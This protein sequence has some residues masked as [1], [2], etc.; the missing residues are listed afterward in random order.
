M[1]EQVAIGITKL[2]GENWTIWKF[3][4]QVTLKSK[5]YFAVVEGIT[6]RPVPPAETKDWDSKDARAQE[7]IVSRVDDKIV[8]HLLTCQTSADMWKKLKNI[9]EHQSQ[10]SVHLLTQKF[11]SLQYQEGHTAE[12]MSQLEEIKGNLKALGEEISDKM[13]VTKVLMSLPENMKHFVT[14]WESTPEANR[15]LTDLMS[16]LMLEEERNKCSETSAAL[17]VQKLAIR[18]EYNKIGHKTQIKCFEC[19]GPHLRRNC[20]NLVKINC[21]FCKKPGHKEQFCWFKKQKDKKEGQRSSN[22]ALISESVILNCCDVIN[23]VDKE[24]LNIENWWMDSGSTEHMCSDRKQFRA[25]ENVREKKQV[26]V[27]NGTMVDVKG[28][29]TV[30]VMAWNGKEWV[31]TDLNNALYIPELAVNLFSLSTALDKNLEMHS[32]K[33]RCQL[34]DKEGK[35]KAIAKRQGNLYKMHFKT[36]NFV[37]EVTSEC[38][39]ASLAE[40]HCRLAHINFEQ[41][42]K[43]LKRNAIEYTEK[44]KPFCTSCLS[45]KQHRLPFPRSQTITEKIGDLV[46]GD[47]EGPIE[48]SSVGGARYFLLMKDDYSRYRYVYF[49]KQKSEAFENIKKFINMV[50][51]QTE[52][53]VKKLRTD[54]GL[55]FINFDLKRLADTKGFIHETTCSDTPQQNGRAEREMRTIME[56][57]RTQLHAKSIDKK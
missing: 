49:M 53:K 50:E 37:Q 14:A 23:I 44:E 10:V 11:F 32:D 47:L 15:T 6:Q 55:E 46:H 29:G 38:N 18:R 26:R 8:T 5:G 57:C 19:E 24:N 36:Q 54:N 48:V 56:A 4:V 27:G 30:Q 17:A 7:I 40:W 25:M 12:F 42:R 28:I 20:P 31:K 41:V 21:H 1:G 9:Y 13:I 22:Q 39:L 35:V 51:T 52:N 33:D 3:Q 45:G 43:L 16:R 2:N 34:L